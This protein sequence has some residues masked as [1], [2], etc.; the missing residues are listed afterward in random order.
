MDTNIPLDH[1]PQIYSQMKVFHSA[2]STFYAPSDESG[3]QGMK[4]E[5]IRS[6]P[7]WRGGAEHRDCALIITDDTKPGM[8]GMQ[9]VQVQLLFSFTYDFTT[10]PCALVDWFKVYGS[11]PDPVTGLWRVV[12]ET[13]KGHRL[14]T[15][16]HLDTFYRNVHL[17]PSFG[18]KFLPHD[19]PVDESLS[20]FKAYFVNKYADHHSHEVIF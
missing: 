8:K 14:R 4:Q 11:H 20:L 5:R 1:C 13:Y 2:V 10:Y 15:V 18:D 3:I 17:M 19:F 16:V 9:V 6:T 12:P 7:S